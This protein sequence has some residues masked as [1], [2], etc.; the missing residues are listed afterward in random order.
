MDGNVTFDGGCIARVW[1][2]GLSQMNWLEIL[3]ESE[4]RGVY[5]HAGLS[6]DKRLASETLDEIGSA[7]SWFL[8][9]FLLSHL[10]PEQGSACETEHAGAHIDRSVVA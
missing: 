4:Y 9:S 6:G 3:F 7:W 8:L 5:V 2:F 1:R 10:F